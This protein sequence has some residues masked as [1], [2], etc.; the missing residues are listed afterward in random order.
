MRKQYN[1]YK[2][3]SLRKHSAY[4]YERGHT[5]F[6]SKM[7]VFAILFRY[8]FHSNFLLERC[9]QINAE[10]I[11]LNCAF[12]NLQF[13]STKGRKF[14]SHKSKSNKELAREIHITYMFDN[15]R[16][17]VLHFSNYTRRNSNKTI[18]FRIVVP[19]FTSSIYIPLPTS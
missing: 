17:T 16:K 2:K 19:H 12:N 13:S 15:E 5:T 18:K 3:S 6:L 8:K 7:A 11:Y 4:E 10:C 14:G 9:L 1:K